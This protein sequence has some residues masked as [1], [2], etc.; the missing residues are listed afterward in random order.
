MLRAGEAALGRKP[1]LLV[2]VACGRG[3]TTELAAGLY[4]AATIMGLDL[5]WRGLRVARRHGTL[6]AAA[7]G[8]HLPI[9]AGRV[10]LLLSIE[11]MMV[12]ARPPFLAEA[13]RVLAPG[14]VLAVTGTY[15]GTPAETEAVL[16]AEAGCLGLEIASLEDITAGVVRACE[17]DAGRRRQWLPPVPWLR[18]WVAK[19]CALPGSETF[20]LYAT[21]RRCYYLASFRR[22]G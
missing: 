2:D 20:N 17:A 9:G 11:A 19:F 15:G 4:P 7:D 14:G 21:G 5:Q 22:L 13:A 8:R 18:G 6:A 10:D 12:V 1:T 16:R 3:G